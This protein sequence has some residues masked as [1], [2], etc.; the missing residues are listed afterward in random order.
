MCTNS[1]IDSDLVFAGPQPRQL[2]IQN[3]DDLL[4]LAE[5]RSVLVS[6]PGVVVLNVLRQLLWKDLS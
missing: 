2:D 5:V 3:D 6:S 4:N 1:T